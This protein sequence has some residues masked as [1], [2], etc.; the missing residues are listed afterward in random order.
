MEYRWVEDI[1]EF[2]NIAKEWDEALLASRNR[3]P[4][5]LADF[6]TTWCRYFCDDRNLRIFTVFNDGKIA[7]GM[8]LYLKKTGPTHAFARVL[9]YIGGSA[10]SYT[11]PLYAAPGAKVL[12]LFKE[13]LSRR[14]D[15]D[16]FYLSDV[17]GEND[18][19]A[20]HHECLSDK[21]FSFDLI[22]DHMNLAIDLSDGRERYLATI[23]GKLKRDLRAKRRHLEEKYGRLTLKEISGPEE[24][25]RYFDIYTQFSLKAFAARGRRS[26][27]EDERRASFL[28]DFFILMDRGQRLDAHAL[29]AGDKVM[30]VSFAYRFGGGFNWALTSFNHD[31]RYF[32][33]GYLLIEELIKEICDR[34]ETYYNW[35]GYGR[36]YKG[37][38][39]NNQTPLYKLFLVRRTPKGAC[40][41]M[42]QSAEKALRANKTIVK[43][44]RKL[45]KA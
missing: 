6:I 31:Y 21:R 43:L 41:R 27:F 30:A 28:K 15:W 29:F 9:S 13:A 10:A 20:E 18:L 40:F 33:P 12:P 16:V 14:R 34:G 17:R 39:C 36:F 5:L 2:S 19:I 7:G 45:N 44:V 11:E 22:Q 23:S 25:K 24:I 1:K 8:P 26:T 4:F 37:Q 3:N 32:R 35:Y 42:L 38:W